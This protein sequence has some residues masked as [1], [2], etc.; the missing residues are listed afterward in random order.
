MTLLRPDP[1]EVPYAALHRAKIAAAQGRM[2]KAQ[3]HLKRARNDIDKMDTFHHIEFRQDI[4]L[5][6]S[7]KDLRKR[8]GVKALLRETYGDNSPLTL[9]ASPSPSRATNG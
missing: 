2:R 4:R 3:R 7:L 8:A 9:G 5:D 1:S 6:P